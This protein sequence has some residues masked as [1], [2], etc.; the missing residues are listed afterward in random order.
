VYKVWSLVSLHTLTL[1]IAS[2]RRIWNSTSSCDKESSLGVDIPLQHHYSWVLNYVTNRK[3]QL[4]HKEILRDVN[5]VFTGLDSFGN[6]PAI[7]KSIITAQHLNIDK[8]SEYTQLNNIPDI[9]AAFDQNSDTNPLSNINIHLAVK[10][11]NKIIE[12][13]TDSSRKKV[14]LETQTDTP[15]ISG[16][17]AN[18][19][20]RWQS[21]LSIGATAE[22]ITSH[23]DSATKS[24][25][26]IWKPASLLTF[27]AMVT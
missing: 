27:V 17:T 1:F 26:L 7:A 5:D 25:P 6:L 4:D 2:P 8:Q 13:G 15:A 24:P 19:S 10:R 20:N 21:A 16:D 14:C 9:I 18:R 23:A 22:A 12:L 11:Q 3:L